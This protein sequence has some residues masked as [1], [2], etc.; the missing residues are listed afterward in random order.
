MDLVYIRGKRGRKVPVLMDKVVVA[1]IDALIQ[2]RGEAGVAKDNKYV[3]AA[4]TRGSMKHLR[5]PDCLGAAVKLC[6]LKKPSAIRSTK[7]RKYVATVSQIIDLQPSE[8]EWLA[9]HMGHDISVHREYY[10]LHD[11]TLELSKVSR[12]LLA[13]DEGS[14]S[15]WKGKK[16]SEIQLDGKS[17][18]ISVALIIFPLRSKLMNCSAT[19]NSHINLV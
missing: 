16:L 5:G 19:Y 7:L 12:L 4:P 8:L 9:S 6:S 11:S 3:F 18:V 14:A 2:K 17:N 15:K 13:I 10:R 1:A